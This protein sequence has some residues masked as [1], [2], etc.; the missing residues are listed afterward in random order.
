MHCE[1]FNLLAN[2]RN[3]NKNHRTFKKLSDFKKCIKKHY[4]ELLEPFRKFEQYRKK[5]IE[6]FKNLQ[7]FRENSTKYY[8]SISF[9]NYCII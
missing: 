8:F 2:L 7:I 9:L 6:H 5:F 4:I 1:L 3:T